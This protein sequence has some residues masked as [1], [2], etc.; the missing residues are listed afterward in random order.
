MAGP[1]QPVLATLGADVVLSC[2]L[3]P[4]ADVTE[5]TMEW[6][7][8]D[9][10]PRFV[11]LRRDGM[12]FLVNQHPLYVGRTY[13]SPGRLK[14]GDLSLRLSS[15]RLSDQGTYR[16]DVPGKAS[17]EVHLHVGGA[18]ATVAVSAEAGQSRGGVLLGCESAGWYPEP[19]LLWLDAE[20]KPVSAGPSQTHRGPDGLYAISSRVTVEKRTSNTLSCR[21]QQSNISQSR[22]AEFSFKVEE[23]KDPSGSA[24]RVT[25][26]LVL[27]AAVIVWF[28]CFFGW[29]KLKATSRSDEKPKKEEEEEEF[30]KQTTGMEDLEEKQRL[31]EDLKESQEEEKDLVGVIEMLKKLEKELVK[32]GKNK[33]SE[34]QE[35]ER[36][37][38]ENHKELQ[39]GSR[40]F[41]K[42]KAEKKA[43]I[44]E[45]QQELDG[46]KKDLEKFLQLTEDRAEEVKKT[47]EVITRQRDGAGADRVEVQSE[48]LDQ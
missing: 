36:K 20:G 12:E 31:A 48:N 17:V 38:E 9:L 26:V 14:Q 18:P 8:S 33:K 10:S 27:A 30:P 24:A 34:L 44:L 23:S 25:A 28:S 45:E 41:Q 7:R 16:C 11:H 3:E 46:K 6:S 39:K 13:L 5:S 22:T 29:W 35:V 2:Q 42:M 4:A 47:I 21:V 19:E 37:M 32:S 43:F 1:S 40:K 15:V